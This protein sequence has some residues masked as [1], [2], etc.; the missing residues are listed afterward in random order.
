M[1]ISNSVI[2]RALPPVEASQ[3]GH[4]SSTGRPVS[5]TVPSA[6]MGVRALLAHKLE[7]FQASALSSGLRMFSD[8]AVKNAMTY[9]KSAVT[10]LAGS[11]AQKMFGGASQA[12]PSQARPS[13]ATPE[14][15]R[16]QP[17]TSIAQDPGFGAAFNKWVADNKFDVPKPKPAGPADPLLALVTPSRVTQASAQPAPEAAAKAPQGDASAPQR[18]IAQDPGFGAALDKWAAENKFDVAKPKLAQTDP[19]LALVTP[20][21][22]AQPSAQPAATAAPQASIKAPAARTPEQPAQAAAQPLAPAAPQARPERPKAT[23]VRTRPAQ[24]PQP[25]P[26]SVR[27]QPQKPASAPVQTQPAQPTPTP[28]R[29]QAAQPTPTDSPTAALLN[30][31]TELNSA[32]SGLLAAMAQLGELNRSKAKAPTEDKTPAKASAASQS[33][34][35]QGK[36]FTNPAEFAKARDKWE[37][38]HN[39]FSHDNPIPEGYVPEPRPELKSPSTEASGR[40]AMSAAQAKALS[41]AESASAQRTMDSGY[42]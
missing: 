26:V 19:L 42:R 4:A 29:T 36:V 11:M 40:N 31:A 32:Q 41:D 24:P 33:T 2:P 30:R 12:R 9:V 21:R 20:S 34:E 28:P 23:S 7:G 35:A 16:Q 6:A 3:T 25:A 1:K 8:P 10:N 13:P 5:R 18:S 38:E 22:V 37:L 17:Q 39:N 14:P 27:T 15:Q